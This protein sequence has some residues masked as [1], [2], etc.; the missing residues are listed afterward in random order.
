MDF[1]KGIV[2]K[3]SY[4]GSYYFV[5]VKVNEKIIFVETND[6]YD[7]G[8]EV[9]LKWDLDAIHLMTKEDESLTN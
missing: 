7:V 8:Q 1:F 6:N 3:N 9:F 4:K 5:D 2:V